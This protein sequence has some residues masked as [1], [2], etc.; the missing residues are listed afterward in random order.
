MKGNPIMFSHFGSFH[1]K[2]VY[3][4]YVIVPKTIASIS[5]D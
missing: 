5:V 4:S 2:H 3:G 1:A